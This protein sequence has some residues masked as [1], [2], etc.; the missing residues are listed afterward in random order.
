[1]LR[2]TPKHGLVIRD[3][4]HQDRRIIPAEGILVS[5]LNPFWLRRLNDN[6]IVVVDEST[7]PRVAPIQDA[8]TPEPP[9]ST[10]S[11]PRIPPQV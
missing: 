7:V 6:D 1:M 8:R 2:I 5:K 4:E 9:I 10:P 3:P 11:T